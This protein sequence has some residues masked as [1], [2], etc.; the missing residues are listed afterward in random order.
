MTVFPNPI[1]HGMGSRGKSSAPYRIYN[2]GN[3]KPE[4]LMRFIAVLERELGTKAKEFLPLQP[5]D[6][7]E[8]YADISDLHRVGLNR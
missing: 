3:N 2:I 5:G 6:V 1:R 8:T 4:E 7:V